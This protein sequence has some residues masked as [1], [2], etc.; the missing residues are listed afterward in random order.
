MYT[1]Q[2]HFRECGEIRS[3]ISSFSDSFL[4]ATSKTNGATNKDAC[5]RPISRGEGTI[6]I[7]IIGLRIEE[8]TRPTTTTARR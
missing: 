7:I 1:I 4:P 8:M 2:F 5:R 6:A 3:E